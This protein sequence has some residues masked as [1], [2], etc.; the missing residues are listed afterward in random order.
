MFES[1]HAAQPEGGGMQMATSESGAKDRSRLPPVLYI[2]LLGL[3]AGSAEGRGIQHEAER[4]DSSPA[5]ALRIRKSRN[6]TRLRAPKPTGLMPASCFPCSFEVR[7]VRRPD[8]MLEVSARRHRNSPPT[9]P[10]NTLLSLPPPVFHPA[11]LRA[12]SSFV[13]SQ[14]DHG[15]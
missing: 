9:P 12:K 10:R 4:N 1:L 5:I 6:F 14:T 8:D 2:A 13:N 15:M 3:R 7:S 11:K